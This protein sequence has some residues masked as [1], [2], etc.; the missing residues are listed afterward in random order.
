MPRRRFS[1]R[2]ADPHDLYERS[3]QDPAADIR[4]LS[5]WFERERGR[6]ALS[7]R[8][9][10]C[11][12]AFLCSEWIRSRRDRT[13]IGIDLDRRTMEWGRR[14]HFRPGNARG[15]D[16]SRMSFLR[17]DVRA[18]RPRGIDVACAFNFSWCTFR[19]RP[20]LVRYLR[21]VRAALARDGL[22]ALDV[23]GGPE[24]LRKLTERRRCGGFTYVWD[25]RPLDP[26][27]H[28]SRR[29]IH[30]EFPDGTRLRDAFTYDWR[31][32]SLPELRDAL[33]DAGFARVDVLWEGTD[34]KGEGNGVFRRVTSA[35]EED[36]WVAYLFAWR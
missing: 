11:G 14:R 36:S 35:E 15:A 20:M 30:F 25:Q 33:R 18:A 12:T 9:D 7:L 26:V 4:L 5:R 2:D 1:A 16:P 23:H 27:T 22:F 34:A 31:M 17:A 6:E 29:T 3:V 13:A 19:E 24:S 8:E 21:A 10:F 32:W 28:R